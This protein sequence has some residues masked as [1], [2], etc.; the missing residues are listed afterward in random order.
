MVLWATNRRIGASIQQLLPRQSTFYAF[1]LT[2]ASLLPFEKV[3][4]HHA[5]T[6]SEFVREISVALH[7]V[8]T[9]APD[10]AP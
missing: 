3:T 7:F 1:N 9:Y 10:S 2:Y 6:L 8:P 5:K 4:V